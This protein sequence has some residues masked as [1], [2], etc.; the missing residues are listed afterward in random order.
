MKVNEQEFSEYINNVAVNDKSGL[1]NQMIQEQIHPEALVV[2]GSYMYVLE[3]IAGLEN[4]YIEELKEVL[5]SLE[6]ESED[7]V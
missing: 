4:L 3:K 2:L 7:E 5:N 6:E 1:F